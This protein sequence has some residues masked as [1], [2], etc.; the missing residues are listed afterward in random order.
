[1]PTQKEDT[2]T[3]QTYTLQITYKQIT[4]SPT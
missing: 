3:Y 4:A 1:M 2:N